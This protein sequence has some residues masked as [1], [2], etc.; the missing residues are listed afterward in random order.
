[1][2][3]QQLDVLVFNDIGLSQH[4]WFLA[5]GR[6]APVQ[7]LTLSN[8]MTSGLPTIDYYVSTA[9]S[10]PAMQAQQ[11][12]SESLVLLDSLYFH[13]TDP[14]FEDDVAQYFSKMQQFEFAQV[15][16]AALRRKWGLPP[17][18][19]LYFCFQ[20][21]F[22]LH[23][24]FDATIFR[25]LELDANAVVVFMHDPKKPSWTTLLQARFKESATMLAS[26]AAG[27]GMLQ[28]VSLEEQQQLGVVALT[29]LSN[30]RVHFADKLPHAESVCFYDV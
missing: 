4:T 14:L 30:G 27:H 19:N 5:F 22:K 26:G 10:Q 23:P 3:E 1:M 24:E 16:K 21:L 9:A 2:A 12:Y 20:G 28:G 25:I 18:A 17:N 29:A 6:F 13:L 8:G 7:C 15:T 11:K